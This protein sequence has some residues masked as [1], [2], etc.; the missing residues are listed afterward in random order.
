VN[1]QRKI[2]LL[3]TGLLPL[4]FP[5]AKDFAAVVML[6]FVWAVVSEAF[7]PAS[8]T[9]IVEVSAPDQRKQT[10]AVYRL[11]ANLGMSVG[12]AVGGLLATVSFP[13]LFLVDG[14]TTLAIWAVLVLAHGSDSA[15]K[16]VASESAAVVANSPPARS[17]SILTDNAFLRLLV[18]M[19]PVI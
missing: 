3:L 8:M 9:M 2:G 13:A 16:P 19:L 12:P 10:F 17:G 14:A 7:R 11:A 15:A 6:T 1:S 18:A 5:L 4:L